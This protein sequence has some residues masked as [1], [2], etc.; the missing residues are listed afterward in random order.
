MN[1]NGW[2]FQN[3]PQQSTPLRC[4]QQVEGELGIKTYPLRPGESVIA[5][6]TTAEDIMWIKVCNASG[7]PSIKK[8]RFKIEEDDSSN[9]EYVSR[10]D[11]DELSKKLDKLL[12]ERN[13]KSEPTTAIV[14]S[15]AAANTNPNNKSSNFNGRPKNAAG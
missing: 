12:E 4:V 11:F 9:T 13:V 15:D 1:F 6:D 14:K 10:K 5:I 8:I 3:Q 2:S 7:L